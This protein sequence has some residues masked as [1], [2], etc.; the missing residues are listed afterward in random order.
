MK[1]GFD[2]KT[3]LILNLELAEL[4]RYDES[5]RRF[6]LNGDGCGNYHFV[7][8]AGDPSPAVGS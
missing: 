8:L 6:F 4:P 3:L 2:P 7:D 5:D 1:Q